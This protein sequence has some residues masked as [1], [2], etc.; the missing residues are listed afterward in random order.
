[1]VLTSL[2]EHDT[3]L[4]NNTNMNS[5]ITLVEILQQMEDLSEK[6][7]DDLFHQAHDLY[8]DRIVSNDISD[9]ERSDALRMLKATNSIGTLSIEYMIEQI[10]SS[11]CIID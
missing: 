8:I 11:Q 1:M 10:N 2:Y 6:G 3:I 7:L 5:A 9:K 4:K